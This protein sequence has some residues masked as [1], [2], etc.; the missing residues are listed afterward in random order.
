LRVEG[1]GMLVATMTTGFGDIVPQTT[2][3]IGYAAFVLLQV[4]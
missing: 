1:G 2:V 4:P 3:E